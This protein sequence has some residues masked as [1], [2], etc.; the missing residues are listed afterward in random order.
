[1]TCR[2]AVRNSLKKKHM[3]F[4]YLPFFVF[5]CV[6]WP[7]YYHNNCAERL[8]FLRATLAWAA[9]ITTVEVARISCCLQWAELYSALRPCYFSIWCHL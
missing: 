1:M 4:V 3:G 6:Q 8:P 5:F 2:C 9:T 7:L